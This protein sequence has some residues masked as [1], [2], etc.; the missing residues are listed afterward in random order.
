MPCSCQLPPEIYPDATEWGPLLW[1]ILH[2]LAERVGRVVSPLYKED[3]RRTWIQLYKALGKMIPCPSCKDHYDSYL[4]ENPVEK[5]IKE[6]PYDALHDYIKRWF[7]EL[8]N[9]VNESYGKPQFPYEDLTPTF[10]GVNI[11]QTLKTL[12]VPV[13]RA[14]RLRAGQYF[15]YNDFVRYLA[16]LLSLYGM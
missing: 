1:S 14:I 2:A 9:W 6:L 15:G 4:R 13:R 11:R 12:D 16:M 3:E 5:D 7:W 10:Q 8:H